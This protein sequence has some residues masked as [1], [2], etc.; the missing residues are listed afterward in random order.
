M[1]II[2]II[3]ISIA[4][5]M[6]AFSVSITKG[7][8]LKNIT[9][10]QILWFGIFFGGFQALMPLLG[11]ISGSQ[12]EQFVKSIT[13]WI[14]FLLLLFIGLKM[15]YDSLKEDEEDI[16]ENTNKNTNE[17]INKNINENENKIYTKI[18]KDKFSFKELT[19]LA[20]ATSIDAFAVG[21]TFAI[22]KTPIIIPILFIGI[23]SFILSE[24]GIII[25]QKI[26]HFFGNKFEIIGGIV[27]V[28]LGFKILL[29]GIGIF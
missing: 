27:L 7:F 19:L 14:A 20:I 26:G 21:V 28:L 8:T 9:K 6:D 10:M 2:T 29:E 16:K 13:P 24:I 17:N 25:G 15:I 18:S 1:D 3:I 11:Y 23:V 22:L 12:L 4:L 5:A